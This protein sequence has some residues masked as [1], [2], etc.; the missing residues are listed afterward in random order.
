MSSSAI[1]HITDREIKSPH[2]ISES[3]KRRGIDEAF[4]LLSSAHQDRP[5]KSQPSCRD[6]H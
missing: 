4:C 1:Q 6:A 5:A 3:L 2:R